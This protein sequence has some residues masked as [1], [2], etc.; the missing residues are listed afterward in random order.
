MLEIILLRVRI[1]VNTCNIEQK[2]VMMGL[3]RKESEPIN[4]KCE[5]INDIRLIIACRC[6]HNE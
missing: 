1:I 2:F 3:S 4:I 5:V 6:G